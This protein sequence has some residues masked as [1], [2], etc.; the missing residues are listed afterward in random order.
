MNLALCES[1]A[2]VITDYREGEIARPTADHIAT[3]VNQFPVHDQDLILDELLHVLGNSYFNRQSV[4]SFLNGLIHNGK[5]S[6]GNPS[7]FWR[8][9][10]FLNIQQGGNSQ[11]EMLQQFGV[12]LQNNFGFGIQNCGSQSG[13][14]LYIDDVIFSG[15]RVLH[16][17][18]PWIQLVA[19]NTCQL[20]IIVIAFHRGGQWYASQRINKIAQEAGKNISIQ[21]WRCIEIENRRS[22]ISQSDVLCPALFP[23]DNEV[24]QYIAYLSGQGYPPQAR[25]VINPCH[26]S[27]FFG[28]EQGRQTLEKSFLVAGAKIKKICPYLPEAIRPLGYSILKTLGFG[29]VI[30]THRNCPNTCPTAFWVNDPWYPL[31]PRKTN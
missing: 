8:S 17:L 6:L 12:C 5:L 15:N 25:P 28:S 21:W 30:V 27:P 7:E 10:N 19:P 18:T 16:D 4:Y 14:H 23:E 11:K 13:P 29:S 20:H 1:I 22:Y 31:F 9:V 3:W 26:K 2:Q 24:K